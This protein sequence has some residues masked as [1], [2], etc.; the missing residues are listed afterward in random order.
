MPIV[1]WYKPGQTWTGR[2]GDLA[3]TV[4]ECRAELMGAYLMYDQELLALFGFTSEVDITAE[5]LCTY[6]GRNP[7]I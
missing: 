6:T 4:D 5:D 7:L 2:F 1:S 3:T